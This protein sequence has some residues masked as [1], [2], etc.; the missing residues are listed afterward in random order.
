[1]Y[2][3][4][5]VDDMLVMPSNTPAAVEAVAALKTV[6]TLSEL[7]EPSVFLGMRVQRDRVARTIKLSQ[8][9]YVQQLLAEHGA[10]LVGP[11]KSTP[12]ASDAVLVKTAPGSEQLDQSSN[13]YAHI[14]GA[15]LYLQSCTRPDIAH[16]VCLLARFMAAPS[17]PHWRALLWLLRY[18]KETASFGLVLGAGSGGSAGSVVVGYSDSDW[19]GDRDERKSTGGYVFLYGGTA[20]SWRTKKQAVVAGSTAEAEYIAASGATK[21]ALWLK[22]LLHADFGIAVGAL[23]LLIDNQAA[24]YIAD[25]SAASARSKHIDIHYHLVR[26]RVARGDISTSYVRSEDNVADCMTKALAENAFVK[27]RDGMGVH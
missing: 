2:V 8:E 4:V 24:M 18:L 11:G 22:Q 13:P 6:F 27:C 21:E 25:S 9:R 12:M 5:W 15:L 14:V 23:P 20:I 10:E 26:D 19:G 3:L 17:M 7:G 1:V 16:A